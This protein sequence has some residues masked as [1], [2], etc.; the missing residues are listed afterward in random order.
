M[1]VQ[2]PL[3]IAHRGAHE[4]LPE[5]SMPAILR[6]LELGAQGIELD[7][8]AT[9]DDVLVVHHDPDIS[10]GRRISTLSYTQIAAVQLA[11]AVAVPR[12]D[13]VLEAVGTRA[14]VFIETKQTGIEMLL[15]RAVR[16]TSAECAVHSFDAP[17]VSN[18]K[19][20]MPSLRVGLLTTGGAGAALS[21]LA[22]TGADDLW[23]LASDIDPDLATSVHAAGKSVIAWTSNDASEWKRLASF[24]IDGICTDNIGKLAAAAW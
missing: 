9:A 1:A 19:S 18:I 24:G 23:H 6:A 20:F 3:A 11:P 10:D 21:K 12:L 16:N 13:A 15:L 8:H 7:V 17:T 22:S 2:R 4:T 5:N 14:I